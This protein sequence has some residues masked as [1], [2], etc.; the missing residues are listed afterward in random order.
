MAFL[1]REASQELIDVERA[2]ELLGCTP[3]MV[4]KLASEHTI[5][6]VKVGSLTR[7]RPVDIDAYVESR[8]VEGAVE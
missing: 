5:P 8:T 2:S 3:R 6:V 7:F 4:R 1:D